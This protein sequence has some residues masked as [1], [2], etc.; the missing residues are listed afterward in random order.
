MVLFEFTSDDPARAPLLVASYRE[1]GGPARVRG[2]GDFS[3]TI[4][5]L[6]H[7]AQRIGMLW[8][9][10]DATAAE[11]L[12]QE[13]RFDE[14]EDRPFTRDLIDTLLDALS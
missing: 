7:L 10:P 13:R 9:A 3:M 11:Q 5:V 1:A 12:R 6:A 4:A 8:L 14:F 2:R